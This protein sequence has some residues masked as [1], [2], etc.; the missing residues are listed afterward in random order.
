MKYSIILPCYN[1][2]AYIETCLNSIFRNDT[3]SCEII[4]I[5]DGSTDNTLEVIK[6]YFKINGETLTATYKSTPIQIYTQD[7]SG[8]S[9]ARNKG[10]ELARGE[11]LLFIDPDDSVSDQ[12]IKEIDEAISFYQTPLLEILQS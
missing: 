10:I 12:Y 1:I 3:T 8:V 7:N 4:L 2:S 11:Y 6:K 9:K 5:N